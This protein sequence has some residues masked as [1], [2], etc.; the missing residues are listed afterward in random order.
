LLIGIRSP[1]WTLAELAIA[2]RYKKPLIFIEGFD[3]NLLNKLF[4]SIPKDYPKFITKDAEE[5][6][7]V[8]VKV[9]SKQFNN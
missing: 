5:A 9:A 2:Y 8:A 3:E 4:T 6:V 7:K 1:W